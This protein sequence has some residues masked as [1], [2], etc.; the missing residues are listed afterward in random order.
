VDQI[1]LNHARLEKVEP[2]KS[3][4][5]YLN[6]PGYDAD[7]LGFNVPFPRLTN[8][9][10]GRAFALPDL[11]GDERFELKYHHYSLLFNKLRKLAFV[12]GVNVD[13]TAQFQHPRDNEGDHWYFDPR[14]SADGEFQAGEGLYADNRLNRGHLVRS[15]DSGWGATWAEAKLASDDSFHFTNCWPQHEITGQGKLTEAPP[16]LKL[17]DKLEDHIAMEGKRNK[18]KL[19]VFNGPVFRRSD[20]MHRGVKIPK[21][22]W[23]V[24]VFS[25]DAGDPAAAAFLLTQAQLIQGLEEEFDS[26]EYKTV[27]VRIKDVE[28]KTH[29]DFGAIRQWDVIERDG[30]EERFTGAIPAVIIESVDDVVM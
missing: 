28:V 20:Q 13:P 29:L 27:Q 19:S 30:T 17:W 12:S 22:F 23:K 8:V 18:R 21:E 1:I 24:V 3:D 9:V 2:D 11:S 15:A 7:F 4:P 14:V 6:R 10:K 26:G 25:G 5:E 16:A